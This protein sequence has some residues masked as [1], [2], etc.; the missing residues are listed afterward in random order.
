MNFNSPEMTDEERDTKRVKEL[1]DTT[2]R[3][4]DTAL[5]RLRQAVSANDMDAMRAAYAGN[6]G[7]LIGIGA[8]HGYS[9]YLVLTE[10]LKNSNLSLELLGL[11][12]NELGGRFFVDSQY[13]VC[14]FSMLLQ[15]ES[16]TV[17]FEEE[18]AERWTVRVAE[19]VRY[20][21]EKLKMPI[22]MTCRFCMRPLTADGTLMEL[23][24]DSGSWACYTAFSQFIPVPTSNPLEQLLKQ[25]HTDFRSNYWV[26]RLVAAV[27]DE[28]LLWRLLQ[29][30]D[31]LPQHIALLKERGVQFQERRENMQ[32][33]LFLQRKDPGN[34]AARTVMEHKNLPRMILTWGFEHARFYRELP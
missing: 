7:F 30:T 31:F 9:E 15:I 18:E 1:H 3:A 27:E 32:A 33:L 34:A 19:V 28:D 20:L 16:S 26:K 10:V 22:R 11:F 13:N 2:I 24:M 4:R 6:N 23:A 29:Q 5:A 21:V 12:F 17:I 25:R 14:V 8:L